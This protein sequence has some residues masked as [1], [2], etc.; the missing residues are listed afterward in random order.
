MNRKE[1]SMTR[2]RTRF[3]AA[4]LAGT[5][6]GGIATFWQGGLHAQ[7]QAPAAISRALAPQAGFGD[8]VQQVQP[9]VVSIQVAGRAAPEAPF[10]PARAVRGLG[11]GFVM[12]AEGHIVTNAHVVANAQQVRVTL[13]DGR[14]LPARILGVDQRTDIALLKVEA[15]APLPFLRFGDSDAVRVGDW[16]V[17]VGSPFGLNATV[18]AGILSAR[19]REI[20]QGSYDDFLQVDAPINS[21]NSGGP[22]F[23]Q[24]G[25]VV[26]VNTAIYS[27]TGGSVGIGFAIPSRIVQQVAAQLKA[28][29]R[30]DRGF[31]GVTTQPMNAALATA[32]G[33]PDGQGALVAEVGADSPAA[34][35][36]LRPG[37]VVLAVGGQRV[38]DP[39]A[40]A[41]QVAEIPAGQEARLTVRRNGA[42]QEVTVR[43]G[44]MPDARVVNARADGRDNQ[45][46]RAPL[47]LALA[48]APKGEGVVV[49]QLRPG[50]PAAE[51]GLQPGDV[52]LQVAGRPVASPEAAVQALRAANGPVALRVQR[53]GQTLFLALSPAASPAAG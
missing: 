27:P 9:A 11:S 4:L 12:D 7:P 8:L 46:Q 47:G 28:Q 40:L 52:I 6:L 48:P 51:A 37:D 18:T 14:E 53:E 3:V 31:L 19:G 49:A 17:A 44:E 13:A 2:S 45:A 50:S 36:G 22:L 15:G 26:G 34:R 25:S 5:A 16:V 41:R 20:G 39:R 23:A 10:A 21:G 30:V 33:L 35:G 42:E 1:V 29:G 32:L 38:R 43:L 24:D